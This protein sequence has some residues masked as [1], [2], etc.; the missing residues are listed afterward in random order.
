VLVRPEQVRI[1]EIP[2]SYGTVARR[3]VVREG[4]TSWRRVHIP[5]HCQ[6]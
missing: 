1:R 6:D 2:P 5:R 3:V 4:S